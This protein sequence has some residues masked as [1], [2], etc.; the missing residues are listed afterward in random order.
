MAELHFKEFPYKRNLFNIDP[1]NIKGDKRKDWQEKSNYS[2][3]TTIIIQIDTTNVSTQ[4]REVAPNLTFISTNQAIVNVYN[5]HT[6]KNLSFSEFNAAY[7]KYEFGLEK[8]VHELIYKLN[9]AR[10]RAGLMG[11]WFINYGLNERHVE[12]SRS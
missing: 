6:F 5:Y 10:H 2:V 11:E 1:E 9:S 12:V 3:R 7:A 4:E 8:Q